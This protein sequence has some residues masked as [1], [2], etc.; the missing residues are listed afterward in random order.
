MIR[1]IADSTCDLSDEIINKYN[2][3]MVPL[4]I[5][6][7]GKEYKDRVDIQPD[8]FYSKMENLEEEPKTSMPNPG[9]YIKTFD[10]SYKNGFDKIICICMSSGTSGSYQSAVIAMNQYLNENPNNHAEIYVVD[11]KSMSHGSGYLVL[12]TALLLEKEFSFQE[13]INFNEL[14]KTN[15][16]HFLA[17]DDLSHL[18]KSGRLT[19]ASAIIGKLLRLKPIMSMKNGKGAIVAKERGKKRVLKY[20]VREYIKRVDKE[21]N[22]FIIIGYTSDIMIAKNLKKLLLDKCDFK[23]YIYLMQM[24]VS[25]GTHVGLGAVSMFFIEKDNLKNGLMKSEIDKIIEKKNEF[26]KK[27]NK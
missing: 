11:S 3:G 19:N 22:K 7:E 26:I 23:G 12:K 15:I 13:L 8:E 5:N 25:V 9:E 16:K 10:E 14:Y 20:Y 1:I 18:I 24:G 27:F 17:V 6:I 21:A 2:I 4:T